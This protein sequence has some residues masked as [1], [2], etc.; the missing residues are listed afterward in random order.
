MVYLAETSALL[1]SA[2]PIAWP[3]TVPGMAATLNNTVGLR[4]PDLIGARQ[5]V[6]VCV[7][8]VR[9]LG[10]GRRLCPVK[11][12]PAPS[13]PPQRKVHVRESG[14]SG[15][16]YLVQIRSKETIPG[17]RDG[18]R[19][20]HEASG[21]PGCPIA[22]A[23]PR[24][25]P[26]EQGPCLPAKI[27]ISGCGI[28][29]SRKCRDSALRKN[30]RSA[31]SPEIRRPEVSGSSPSLIRV[32]SDCWGQTVHLVD[33]DAKHQTDRPLGSPAGRITSSDWPSCTLAVNGGLWI[34]RRQGQYG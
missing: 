8:R 12:Y 17:D 14:L 20:L 15:I 11:A 10:V 13:S 29:R 4:L 21:G 33:V 16:L 26:E 31:S 6:K 19:L 9:S 23:G 25:Q 2:N 32:K 30:T 1:G 24:R 5:Q 3:S 7:K 34:L 22:L 28:L 27:I 18:Q